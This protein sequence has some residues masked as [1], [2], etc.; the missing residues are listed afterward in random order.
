[1]S[2][3]I[4]LTGKKF[5]SWTVISLNRREGK[6]TYWNCICGCRQVK[7]VRAD[8]LMNGRSKHC[9]YCNNLTHHLS[10]NILYYT[11]YKLRAR[12]YNL[13]A[14]G[15][16]YWGGRGIIICDEWKNNFKAFYD[17]SINNGWEEGLEIDRI[18]NN[19]NYEPSNCRWTTSVINNRNKRNIKL[20]PQKVEEIK[21]L[22]ANHL[23]QQ[24]IADIYNVC[25]ESISRINTGK[26]W[27]I[28]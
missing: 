26:Q 8:A 12:C 1:M 19:G 6:R 14:T 11:F 2:K 21:Q 20:N 27:K 9:K 16:K 17:W 15:Y 24:N 7:I 13:K 25:R 5:N 4:D 28:I 23:T 22:I 3:L 10:K 18:N